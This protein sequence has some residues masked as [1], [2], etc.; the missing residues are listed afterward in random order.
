MGIAK[1]AWNNLIGD[2]LEYEQL[3]KNRKSRH[4]LMFSFE[5]FET[6]LWIEMVGI[7]FRIPIGVEV[8]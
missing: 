6:G 3:R 2:L 5:K 8:V 7:F 4:E 1:K